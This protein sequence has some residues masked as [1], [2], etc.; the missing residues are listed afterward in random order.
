MDFCVDDLLAAAESMLELS[1]PEPPVVEMSAGPI[2]PQLADPIAAPIVDAEIGAVI[3]PPAPRV[4]A[5][6]PQWMGSD[7]RLSSSVMA[8]AKQFEDMWLSTDLVVFPRITITGGQ[9]SISLDQSDLH[10]SEGLQKA[11]KEAEVSGSN[12]KT[13]KQ[14][15]SAIAK[16]ERSRVKFYQGMVQVGGQWAAPA[17]Q[18]ADCC[19]K[20][21]DL[22]DEH[23]TLSEEIRAGYDTMRDETMNKI[24][25]ILLEAGMSQ[26]DAASRVE[27]LIGGYPT[28]DQMLAGFRVEIDPPRFCPKLADRATVSAEMLEARIREAAAE[29]SVA[30]IRVIE[31]VRQRAEQT[32]HNTYAMAMKDFER[33]LQG[34]LNDVVRAMLG[35][36][37][38]PGRLT[39]AMR[40]SLEIKLK[41]L[42]SMVD[43]PWGGSL[44]E[45]VETVAAMA[46]RLRTD[47]S[48]KVDDMRKEL[49]QLLSQLVPVEEFTPEVEDGGVNLMFD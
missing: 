32:L 33:Q 46:E 5:N 2:V 13:N 6:P 19:Q 35:K 9:R 45:T 14:L 25:N 18:Y 1:D 15:L 7:L 21:C 42:R 44:S 43:T 22:M 8:T 16:L 26:F 31:R 28:V 41:D 48:V 36:S 4:Q 34:R 12:V 38:K 20:L 40:R 27:K 24:L 37:I 29:S 3:T 47:R 23:S 17:H 11:L 30:E 10:M 49:N 39:D